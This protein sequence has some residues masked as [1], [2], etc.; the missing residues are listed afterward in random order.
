MPHKLIGFVL[1]VVDMS[2]DVEMPFE[3]AV[4]LGN[5]EM[6]KTNLVISVG[7]VFHFVNALE[8]RRCHGIIERFRIV[9]SDDE[10]LFALE[11]LEIPIR[12]LFVF[13]GKIPDNIN[14]VII[15]N[16]AVP[17][18]DKSP[19]HFVDIGERT[20][21]KFQNILVTEVQIGCVK[22]HF[23]TSFEINNNTN[24]SACQDNYTTTDFVFPYKFVRT[25]NQKSLFVSGELF[26]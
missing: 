14:L 16:S 19:V 21:I 13:E 8:T 15:G 11:L 4:P 6:T 20:V 9:V 2:V 26:L 25:V 22:N 5:R 1:A 12:G 24:F 17:Q 3:I 10:M 18:L 23:F 7:D